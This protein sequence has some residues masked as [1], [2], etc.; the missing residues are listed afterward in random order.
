MNSYKT[1][2]NIWTYLSPSEPE[3]QENISRELIHL[4]MLLLASRQQYGEQSARWKSSLPGAEPNRTS[5][6]WRVKCEWKCALRK[7]EPPLVWAAVLWLDQ[8]FADTYWPGRRSWRR[9]R[10][11]QPD[12]VR[13][14]WEWCRRRAESLRVQTDCPAERRRTLV[15]HEHQTAWNT[16]EHKQRPEGERL[17]H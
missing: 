11:C 6:G 17:T 2:L 12:P 9:Q 1:K 7:P 4:L 14:W 15:R 5:T 8:S 10:R 16:E 13:S 3:P